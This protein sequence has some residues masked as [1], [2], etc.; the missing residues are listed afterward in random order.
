MTLV[1]SVDG[2]PAA[3]VLLVPRTTGEPW[4]AAYILGAAAGPPPGP[5]VL[6]EVVTAGLA[7][8]RTVSVPEGQYYLVLD[9]T[10]TAGRASPTG[11]AT[12]SYA[13]EVAP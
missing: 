11:T 7:F 4:L 1:V 6:D 13:I 2:V 8:R 3:D 9:N 12:V 5:S 10:A